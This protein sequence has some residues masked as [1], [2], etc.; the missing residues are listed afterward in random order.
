MF[1]A[2]GCGEP[3]PETL[4]HKQAIFPTP[5]LEPGLVQ[6]GAVLGLG[7]EEN[8]E[9]MAFD[10]GLSERATYVLVKKEVPHPPKPQ[11]LT[12]TRSPSPEPAAQSP[13]RLPDRTAQVVWEKEKEGMNRNLKP[14]TRNRRMNRNLEPG[15]RNQRTH[16]GTSAH[17]RVL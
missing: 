14:G 17:S 16:K 13:G 15:T 11:T 8:L 1:G 6:Q 10:K 12:P 7:S 3:K 9:A 5:D 4:N 2:W